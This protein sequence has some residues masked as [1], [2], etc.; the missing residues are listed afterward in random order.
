MLQFS[1][2]PTF[3]N[4]ITFTSKIHFM[5]GLHI[6][7]RLHKYFG[8]LTLKVVEHEKFNAQAIRRS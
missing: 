1:V 7:H 8:V 4:W 2:F 3:F 5:D 6:K